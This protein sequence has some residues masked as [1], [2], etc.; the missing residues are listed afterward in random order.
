MC[1]YFLDLMQIEKFRTEIANAQCAKFIEDQIL[2][3]WQ[4]YTKKRTK[5]LETGKC[6]I[7]TEGY[8]LIVTNI[9]RTE[10]AV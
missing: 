8:I 1:L 7:E 5:I 3:H 2:L 10:R 6:F 9:T 4:H